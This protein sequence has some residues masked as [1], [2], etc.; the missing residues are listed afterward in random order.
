MLRVGETAPDF[1]LASTSG[2]RVNL[3]S[4]KG[5]RVV[6]YFY[7]RDSTPGCTQEACDF[8]DA[9]VALDAVVLGVSADS[10]GSH[11]K[12]RDKHQLPFDLLTDPGNAVARR[13]GAYGDKN[14]YGR[15]VKG[16]IR[17]TFL[18]GP[19]GQIEAIWSP[20]RV[21][22]HVDQVLGALSGGGAPA[23]KA[24]AKKVTKKKATKKKATK[25]KAA[26]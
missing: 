13:Y 19:T 11:D 6:L 10:L 9:H 16:T 1:D 2:L 18:I 7:P 3:E 14:M 17:S 20:V 4:L 5:R 15:T 24:T 8:R 12:F 21:K 26:R 25:K 23:K 22:G